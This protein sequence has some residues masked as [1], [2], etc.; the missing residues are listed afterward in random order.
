M[1]HKPL[2]H[3]GSLH[4]ADFQA[5]LST[6]ITVSRV[7]A[8][9][10]DCTQLCNTLVCQISRSNKS[11]YKGKKHSCTLVACCESVELQELSLYLHTN[12]EMKR[13]LSYPS[14]AHQKMKK[15]EVVSKCHQNF[16]QSPHNACQKPNE[17]LSSMYKLGIL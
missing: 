1:K 16:Q 3:I 15:A 12:L 10:S 13:Q 17:T 2:V 9:A 7:V 5:K 11:T 14:R 8:S 4:V 6:T